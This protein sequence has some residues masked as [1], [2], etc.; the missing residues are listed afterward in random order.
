MEHNLDPLP[1][2]TLHISGFDCED[3]G[4]MELDKVPEVDGV[5]CQG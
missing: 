5:L 1:D 3:V 2:D 4:V